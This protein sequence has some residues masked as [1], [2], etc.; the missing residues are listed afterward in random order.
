[1]KYIYKKYIF[2][3][4]KRVQ[5]SANFNKHFKLYDHILSVAKEFSWT[6]FYSALKSM[7]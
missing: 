3:A 6:R 7:L 5:A 1:M 2:I 4:E